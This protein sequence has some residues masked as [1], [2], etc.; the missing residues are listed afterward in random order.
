MSNFWKKLNKP[1]FALAPM[2]EVTDVAFREMFARYSKVGVSESRISEQSGFEFSDIRFSNSDFVMYT[3][4]VN[5]DGLTHPEGRKKL[6]IDLKF[7][8]EQ[9]PIVAQIWGTNPENFTRQPKFALS[10]VLTG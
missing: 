1:I 9:K 8:P 3:E 6:E 5:V 2:E 4:F 7:T 10:L